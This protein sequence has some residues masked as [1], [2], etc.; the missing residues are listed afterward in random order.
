MPLR[1]L[2]GGGFHSGKWL[3]LHV[4]S[5]SHSLALLNPE[6]FIG[7]SS[8]DVG[9]RAQAGNKSILPPH[10]SAVPARTAVLSAKSRSFAS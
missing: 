8:R 5:H 7:V 9:V 2:K 6:I 10:L 4:G 3:L 1:R